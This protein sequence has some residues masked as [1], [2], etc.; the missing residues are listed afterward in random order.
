[1]TVRLRLSGL[2]GQVGQRVRRGPV[3]DRVR[4]SRVGDRI[5]RRRVDRQLRT[6]A[7]AGAGTNGAAAGPYLVSSGRCPSCDQESR[8]VAH[9]DWLRDGF[10]CQKCGSVP[11]ERAVM[12]AIETFFPGWRDAVVHESSPS[13]RATSARLARECRDYTGSQYFPDGKPGEWRDG[14]L[15]QDL[16]NQSFADGS[17]DLHVSQDVLEHVFDPAAVF[18]EVARTLKPGGMHIFTT[19]LVR[20]EQP[21][22]RR[23]RLLPDGEVRNL[24]PAEFHGNPISGE[25]SLVTVDW[26]FDIVEFIQQASGLPTRMVILDDLA[27]GI[28]AEYIEVLVTVKPAHE[29]GLAAELGDPAEPAHAG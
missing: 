28:R 9:T 20:K 23:A 15:H 19:P 25:G 22:R 13:Q 4:R 27:H 16:E 21:S 7:T 14:H 11:R 5:R 6:G 24:L 3:A 1:M 17:V 29:P 18:R 10:L 26:G 8:F 12:L 2:S